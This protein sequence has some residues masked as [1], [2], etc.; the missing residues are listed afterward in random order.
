LA[1]HALSDAP[2]RGPERPPEVGV[3][4]AQFPQLG[5]TPFFVIVLDVG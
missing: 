5:A 2:G 4:A 1:L 3:V